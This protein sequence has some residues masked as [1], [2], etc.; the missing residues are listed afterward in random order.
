[1][2]LTEFYQSMEINSRQVIC[3]FQGEKRVLCYLQ[4]FLT[5]PAYPRLVCSLEH[6]DFESAY[7]AAHA[8]MGLCQNLS[9]APLQRSS[10][11][12]MRALREDMPHAFIASLYAE[13]AADYQRTTDAIRAIQ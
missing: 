3:R 11:R 13:V 4:Q 7:H 2:D 9:L 6:D 8:L 10:S 1:M 5:D 12:L